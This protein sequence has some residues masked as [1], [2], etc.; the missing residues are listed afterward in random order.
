MDDPDCP[1]N[2]SKANSV[3][4]NVSRGMAEGCETCPWDGALCPGKQGL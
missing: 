4:F 2:S 1:V 3:P